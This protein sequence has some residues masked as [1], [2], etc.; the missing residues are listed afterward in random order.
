MEKE[1]PSHPSTDPAA[2]S[3]MMIASDSATLQFHPSDL[4]ALRRFHSVA[5]EQAWH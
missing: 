3:R 5:A 4:L 1:R 2:G